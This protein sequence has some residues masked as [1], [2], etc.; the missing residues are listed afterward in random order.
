MSANYFD[1][2]LLLQRKEDIKRELTQALLAE[3]DELVDELSEK[4]EKIDKHI[5]D[6]PVGESSQL[7]KTNEPI[8]KIENNGDT[9]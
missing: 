2:Q 9:T 5:E 3:D 8:K 4:L 6:T 7:F 1:I